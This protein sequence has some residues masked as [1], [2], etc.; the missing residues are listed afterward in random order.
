MLYFIRYA[1]LTHCSADLFNSETSVA[2]STRFPVLD[3]V[4]Q[5]IPPIHCRLHSINSDRDS[6][7]TDNSVDFNSAN[8]SGLLA[9]Q[10]VAEPS[11]PISPPNPS[12]TL[13]GIQHNDP[14]R[15]SESPNPDPIVVPLEEDFPES[16]LF[17]HRKYHRPGKMVPG[18]TP[19]AR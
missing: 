16:T 5:D 12:D 4:P 10:I 6:N 14:L 13:T 1:L 2:D 8:A 17:A 15:A 18:P 7:N 11:T 9:S 19:T 3:V